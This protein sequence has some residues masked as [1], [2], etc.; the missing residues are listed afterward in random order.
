MVPVDPARSASYRDAGM[1]I[2]REP[3]P[4]QGGLSGSVA[5]AARAPKI[6]RAYLYG[7]ASREQLVGRQRGS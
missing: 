6:G 3:M 1:S 4:H 2:A 7:L 5:A